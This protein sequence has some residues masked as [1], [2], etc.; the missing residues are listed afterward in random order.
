MES[1]LRAVTNDLEERHVLSKMQEILAKKLRLLEK[2]LSEVCSRIE[3]TRAT[4]MMEEVL[5]ATRDGTL[6][7]VDA[8]ML[9][10]GE[11]TAKDPS[12]CVIKYEGITELFNPC[13]NWI[14]KNGETRMFKTETTFEITIEASDVSPVLIFGWHI[15]F[16]EDANIKVMLFGEDDQERPRRTFVLAEGGN[17]FE[18]VPVLFTCRLKKYRLRVEGSPE[19]WIRG[20]SLKTCGPGR[21]PSKSL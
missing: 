1:A 6:S 11:Y 21:S 12:L 8:H 19:S 2:D 10:T 14:V 7:V 5:G 15:H 16:E 17:D 13:E 18:F 4:I 3:E 9:L 20:I